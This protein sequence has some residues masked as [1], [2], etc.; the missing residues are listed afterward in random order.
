[1]RATSGSSGWAS[2]SGWRWWFNSVLR[3]EGRRL[4]VNAKQILA[5]V[6][7]Q[8]RQESMP[9]LSLQDYFEI[10]SAEQLTKDYS[11][12]FE[13]LEAAIVDG[14][15][16]G[17]IDSVFTFVNGELIHEDSDLKGYRKNVDICL[18][19]IQS[20]SS[21]GFSEDPLNRMKSSLGA[22]LQFGVN[23]DTLTQY[24]DN[25]K[26]RLD[27]FRKCYLALASRFP[28]LQVVVCYASMGADSDPH[29]NIEIKKEEL[30]SS[31]S[32][33]FPDAAVEV[34]LMGASALLDLARTQPNETFELR[35]SKS[36]TSENGYVVLSDLS[37]YNS[38]LR[39][40]SSAIRHDLFESNVR[41]Y[42][43][44]TEVNSD[45]GKTLVGGGDI[46]FWW[47]NNGVTLLAAMAT[48]NGNVV[49]IL[50]PQIVNG[51]QTSSEIAKF[52][53]GGGEDNGRLLMVKIVSSEDEAVRDQI[54]K[55]T[56][57]QNS[58]PRASLR[59]TDKVQRD[60][61]HA[62]KG[63]GYFYDRRKNFYKNQGKPASRI[64]SIPLL[65]QSMMT[66]LRL[67]PDNARARPSSLIKE[68]DVYASL[69]SEEYP[70]DSYVVAADT[71]R[72]VENALKLRTD[73]SARDRN[74]LR[75]YCLLWA[76][77]WAAKT[78][79]LAAS[80]MAALTAKITD[81]D[82]EAAID[83][84]TPLFFDAGGTDQLAKGPDFK[85][86]LLEELKEKIVE[87]FKG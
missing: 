68:D 44:T 9:E 1:L 41:D 49:T 21:G 26:G 38:F 4:S 15:H 28:T 8:R 82:I 25:V 36:L 47:L 59:A 64:V 73:L 58:V 17:G 78:T 3:K 5:E 75:F 24:N 69:F 34:R 70:I 37:D 87:H 55:A 53:D 12:T 45:I 56:N 7:E 50:N 13:E 81:A 65:A 80:K 33:L 2:R 83:S 79:S 84:V 74:N 14:E 72:R 60:I 66:L 85:E 31:L 48:V 61:E 40:G 46:D 43:G 77:A 71:T 54:I 52:F 51:L 42:Q 67:E 35:F 57:S 16:D 23:Y 19:V 10:F 62:L 29:Q 76:V 20:K 22:M 39:N 86:V 18:L 30:R 11:L 63:A 32:D 27:L 6:V